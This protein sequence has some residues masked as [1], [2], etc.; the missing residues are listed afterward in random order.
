MTLR[1]ALKG[2]ILA[3]SGCA[4][5]ICASWTCALT[6][7]AR[8][9]RLEERAGGKW[10]D[11]IRIARLPDKPTH[12]YT[13][14]AVGVTVSVAVRPMFVE[15]ESDIAD[16]SQI[17]FSS[18]W[19]WRSMYGSRTTRSP[20]WD[21]ERG[22]PQEFRHGDWGVEWM[23]RVAE[24]GAYCPIGHL[25]GHPIAIGLLANTVFYSIVLYCIF[26]LPKDIRRVARVFM[27]VCP[28]CGYDVRNL[29]TPVCP[30]CGG[31]IKR[32]AD[33]QIGEENRSSTFI[34]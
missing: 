28:T 17:K 9:G 18:G 2:I 29:Y 4:L 27:K 30:E 16:W 24:S 3:A 22:R 21:T 23:R 8:T 34:G 32:Q 19:P 20:L 33:R 10:P 11:S 31:E 15:S 25:P 7:D 13:R 6:F 12:Q 1:W 5:S 14:D 26:Q